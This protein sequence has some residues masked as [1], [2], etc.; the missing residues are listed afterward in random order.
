MI[1]KVDELNEGKRER[2]KCR[3]RGKGNERMSYK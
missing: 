1:Q 3:N 2:W